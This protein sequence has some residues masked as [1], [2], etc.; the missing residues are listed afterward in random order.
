MGLLRSEY[1]AQPDAPDSAA[2]PDAPDSTGSA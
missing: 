2:Q 1:A